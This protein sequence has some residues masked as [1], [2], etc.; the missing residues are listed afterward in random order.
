ML[1]QRQR[2]SGRVFL[3]LMCVGA[4]ALMATPL[5]AQ[6]T[7]DAHERA[8]QRA[9]E[10]SWLVEPANPE[11]RTI[12]FRVVE[13]ETGAPLAGAELTVSAVW[14]HVGCSVPMPFVTDERGRLAMALPTDMG[15]LLSLRATASAPSRVSKSVRWDMRDREAGVTLPDT[16]TLELPRGTEIGGRVIDE[17][18][19][20]IHGVHVEVETVIGLDDLPPSGQSFELV[21]ATFITTNAEG[22]WRCDIVPAQLEELYVTLHHHGYVRSRGSRKMDWSDITRLRAREA[23]FKMERGFRVAGRVVDE[24]GEPIAG[25]SVLAGANHYDR[26]ALTATTDASGA[27]SLSPVEADRTLSL[28]V[29]ADGH[30]PALRHVE[31][32]RRGGE[33]LV[34]ELGEARTLSGRVVNQAGEPVGGAWVRVDRWRGFQALDIRT[35]T[36]ERGRFELYDMPADEVLLDVG[37]AG[38]MR[39]DGYA[40]SAG[41]EPYEIVLPP[42]LRISGE[43]R[44]KVTGEPIERFTAQPAIGL[45]ENR[46]PT[47]GLN[48]LEVQ[49]FRD[50]KYELVLRHPYPYQAVVVEAKGYRRAISPTYPPDAGDVTCDFELVRGSGPTGVVLDANG[51]PAA[52]AKL[53]I[54]AGGQSVSMQD[55]HFPRHILNE[56]TTADANGRY[57][58]PS[59]I[60]EQFVVVALHDAGC[61]EVKAED[62]GEAGEIVLEPWARIEGVVKIGDGVAAGGRISMSRTPIRHYEGSPGFESPGFES[63]GVWHHANVTADDHGRFTLER[64]PPGEVWIGRSVEVDRA[65]TVYATSMSASKR[66]TVEPGRTY[67]VQ[68]GGTGRPV[69]G[70]VAVVDGEWSELEWT[71]GHGSVRTKRPRLPLPEGFH[72]WPQ[73]KRRAWMDAWIAS[74]EKAEFEKRRAEYERTEQSFGFEVAADGTFEV[75]DVPAG[76]YELWVTL[77]NVPPGTRRRNPMGQKVAEARVE[78]TVPPMPGGRSDDPLDVGKIELERAERVAGR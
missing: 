78:V 18:G 37:R 62:L 30:A 5:R 35:E 76:E 22:R 16:Y 68:I 12:E 63:P 59:P 33:P 69:V 60:Y 66:V 51:E 56:T 20:P 1:E 43:V 6:D 42:V 21:P 74:P 32:G 67:T 27:F 19:G 38:Y 13:A 26:D 2:A 72:Q 40:A 41:D 70:R 11:P 75:A 28:V 77:R 31:P 9:M 23:V 52:G 50:G 71:E 39:V 45:N 46:P 47:P 73:E 36:D 10:R 29:R 34:I 57:E 54:A 55:G 15:R 4:A 8:R 48:P 17:D 25:A 44:D 64:V 53:V 49:W 65:G 14:A 3:A 58:L 7:A 61:A 24:R